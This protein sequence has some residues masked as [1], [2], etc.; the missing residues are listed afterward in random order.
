MITLLGKVDMSNS[1]IAIIGHLY[2]SDRY[3][4]RCE[5]KNRNLKDIL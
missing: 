4:V 5:F 3:V 1:K 2:L